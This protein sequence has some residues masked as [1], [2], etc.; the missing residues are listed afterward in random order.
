[1]IDLNI[2]RH[3][4]EIIRKS[5]KDRGV[6][7]DLDALIKLDEERRVYINKIENLRH[8]QKQEKDQVAAKAIK[9]EIKKAEVKE[10]ELR[11]NFQQLIVK[12]P[13]IPYSNV[14]VHQNEEGNTEIKKMG[15][16]PEGD[17]KEYLEIVKDDIDTERG[18]KTSGSRFYYLKNQVALLELKLISFVVN[19]LSDV[20]NIEKVIKSKKLNLLAKPFIPVVPP[21]M[22]KAEIMKGMGYLDQA[23]DETY[24]L[25]KDDLYL[26]G[27]AEQALVAM[28]ANEI[29]NEKD[30]PLRYVGLPCSAFRRE[31]GS[32]GKDVKGIFRVHQFE[33]VEMVSFA[34]PEQSEAEQQLMVGLEEEILKILKLPARL[35]QICTGDLSWPSAKSFDWECYIPSQ[36]KYCET[37]SCSNCTDFQARRLNIRYKNKEGKNIFLHTLNGT[38]LAM[39]RAIIAIIENYQKKDGG[40]D[41]PKVLK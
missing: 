30:L 10:K 5:L 20:K 27:T 25:E 9:E 41:W 11:D 13:N 22:L 33:K 4:P 14:P 24:H 19:F 40:F 31:A 38:G 26:I 6:T 39:P 15:E 21:I 3:Q 36:K 18:A 28:H 1:M 34:T 2:L 23:P 8:Q 37:H 35:L 16:I 29:F 17:F 12:V 7:F 32:Y